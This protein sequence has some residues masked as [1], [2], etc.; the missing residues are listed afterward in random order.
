MSKLPEKLRPFFWDT[1]FNSIDPENNKEYIIA[2]L[3]TKGD[4]AAFLWTHRYYSEADF[5]AAARERR[6]LNPIVANYLRLKTGLRKEDMAYY[7]VY[8]KLP[9]RG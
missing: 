5:E 9:W 6:D 3:L 7:R 2:R 8:E 4:T 1:D